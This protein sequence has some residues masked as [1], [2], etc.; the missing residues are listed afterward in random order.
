MSQRTIKPGKSTFRDANGGKATAATFDFKAE[1]EIRNLV[2]TMH[3]LSSMLNRDIKGLVLEATAKA[4]KAA[5][6]YTLTEPGR[7]NP[8][9]LKREMTVL[10]RAWNDSQN[11]IVDLP[12]KR[13]KYVVTIDRRSAGRKAGG[14]FKK[15]YFDSKDKAKAEALRIITYRG[16]ARAGWWGAVPKLQALAGF[17]LET[18]LNNIKQTPELIEKGKLAEVSVKDDGYFVS[19]VNTYPNISKF[20]WVSKF[21]GYKSVANQWEAWRK[22]EE[23]KIK[24]LNNG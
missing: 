12:K 18:N 7:R 13:W 14:K 17:P 8:S 16:A 22:K 5:S 19:I 15:N 24:R 20:A 9:K 4:A 6:Q 3:S 10:K 11:K 21:M 23:Q 2:K 1:V